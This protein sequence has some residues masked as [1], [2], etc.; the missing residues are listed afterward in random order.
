[1]QFGKRLA[2]TLRTLRTSQ[3]DLKRKHRAN[4]AVEQLEERQVPAIITDMTQLAQQFARHSGPS[5]VYLNFDGNTAQGVSSFQSISGDRNK[6]IHEIL[7]RTNEIFAPFDVEVRRM[8]G[9]GVADT[10]S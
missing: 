9:N 1:M 10:S 7:F 5:I 4:L 6:D 8:Y 3:T 2:A